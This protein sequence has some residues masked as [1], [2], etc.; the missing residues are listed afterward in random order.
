MYNGYRGDLDPALESG[1][2]YVPSVSVDALP[3]QVDW[4][5]KGYVTGVKNQVPR[6]RHYYR[7][8]TALIIYG[9]CFSRVN[10]VDAGPLAL[11]GLW[12]DSTTMQLEI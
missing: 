12:R 8:L 4:R 1:E 5:E 7:N 6:G 2:P 9:C 10:V 3:D 11:L